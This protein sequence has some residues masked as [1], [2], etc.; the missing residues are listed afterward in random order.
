MVPGLLHGMLMGNLGAAVLAAGFSYVFALSVGS[1]ALAVLRTLGW[2]MLIHYLAAGF[3]AGA[4]SGFL[5]AVFFGLQNFG[6]GS[7]L[8]FLLLLGMYGFVVA[9]VYWSIVFWHTAAKK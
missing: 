4:L 9:L 2:R 5:L 6:L 1:V 8:G 7:A 3:C